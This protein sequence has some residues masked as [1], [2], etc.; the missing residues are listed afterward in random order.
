MADER[1]AD[2]RMADANDDGSPGT[3]DPIRGCSTRSSAELR[4]RAPPLRDRGQRGRGIPGQLRRA[5]VKQR[6]ASR[7]PPAPIT[8]AV[9]AARPERA[10][11]GTARANRWPGP[12]S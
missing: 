1:T 2:E 10:D 4:S 3:W 11:P 8:Q 7:Q 12:S 9:G 6:P 5:C